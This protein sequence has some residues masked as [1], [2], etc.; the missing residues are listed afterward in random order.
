MP[1]WWCKRVH[2]CCR[3]YIASLLV[4]VCVGLRVLPTPRNSI[5]PIVESTFTFQHSRMTMMMILMLA[6]RSSPF[7]AG[8]RWGFVV[9][10]C[11]EKEVWQTLDQ[12]IHVRYTF[13]L[14]CTNNNMNVPDA[15]V[16]YTPSRSENIIFFPSFLF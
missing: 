3:H 13:T 9:V 5:R 11:T 15:C 14:F 6:V 8:F 7:L 16:V 4:L 2:C 12:F 1:V 10:K